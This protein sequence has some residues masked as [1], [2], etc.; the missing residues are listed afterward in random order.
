M[1]HK[2]KHLI[3]FTQIKFDQEYIKKYF[4][5]V[6]TIISITYMIYWLKLKLNFFLLDQL[7]KKYEFLMINSLLHSFYEY[8]DIHCHLLIHT[9]Q[10]FFYTLKNFITVEINNKYD[11]IN[12]QTMKDDLYNFK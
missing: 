1:V 6:S 9:K 10:V 8:A 11:V 3:V 7:D 2:T 12:L 4:S 5:F